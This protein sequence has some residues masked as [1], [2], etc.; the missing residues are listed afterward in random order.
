MKN[1]KGYIALSTVL[2]MLVVIMGIIMTTTYS[3]ITEGQSGLALFQGEQNFQGAEGC[4][5]DVM[6]KIRTNP[7]TV[8]SVTRPEGTCTISYTLSGPTN[9]DMTVTFQS[10]VS[11]NIQRKIKVIFV[12]NPTGITLTSWNEIN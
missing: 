1:S 8:N 7:V 12:R 2:V 3:A 4:A 6:L 9:W 5:E 10:T 11:T